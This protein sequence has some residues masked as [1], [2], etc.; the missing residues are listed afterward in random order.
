MRLLC[1]EEIE[2]PAFAEVV[3]TVEPET[4]RLL[5]AMIL[6]ARGCFAAVEHGGESKLTYRR[7]LRTLHLLTWNAA[8]LLW[9][10]IL[11]ENTRPFGEQPFARI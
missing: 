7:F 8:I 1:A 10:Q 6:Y 5:N 9:Y 4:K 3:A 11:Q 2:H